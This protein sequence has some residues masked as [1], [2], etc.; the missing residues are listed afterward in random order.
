MGEYSTAVLLTRS[1]SKSTSV[2][3]P[4]DALTPVSSSQT[5]SQYTDY[6]IL[7]VRPRVEQMDKLQRPQAPRKA[8]R[9]FSQTM[10]EERYSHS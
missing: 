5:T 6:E 8:L 4:Q 3:V 9:A 2:S 10:F 7:P 1:K